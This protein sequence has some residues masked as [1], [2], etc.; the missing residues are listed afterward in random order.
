MK[1]FRFHRNNTLEQLRAIILKGVFWTIGLGLPP[2]TLTAQQCEIF[3]GGNTPH[4][5]KVTVGLYGNDNWLTHHWDFGDGTPIVVGGPEL[6]E[7]SHDYHGNFNPY[8][9]PVPVARHSQDGINWCEVIV[10]QILPYI[11]IGNGCGSQNTLSNL[12]F[13]NKLPATELIGKQ[14]FI[15]GNLEVDIPYKFS[16][17]TILVLGGG[18][19]TVKSGGALTLDQNTMVDAIFDPNDANCQ[20]LWNGIEVMSGGALTTDH[21]SI[22][23][24]YFAISPV[25]PGNINPLPKLSLRNTTFSS[26]FV[27]IYAAAGSFAVSLFINNTFDGSGNNSIYPASTC[28]T[29]PQISGVPYSQRTYCGIYFDGSMGG[30][31]L[32]AGQSTNNLIKEMQ[33]GIVCING[34]SRITGCRFENIAYLTTVTAAHQGTTLTF[35]DNIGGKRLNFVGLGKENLL[36]TITNCERGVYVKTTKPLTEAY[37][38]SCRM[39]EVQNGVEMEETGMG[40]FARGSVY[41]CYIG[42]TK[43]LPNI[44]N[45]STGIEIKDP[46]IAYSNFNINS[47][48][49]EQD[50]PEAYQFT[51]PTFFVFDEEIFPKGIALSTVHSPLSNMDV[52][53]GGNDVTLIKGHHGIS[54]ENIIN[55]VITDNR[56]VNNL[57]GIPFGDYAQIGFFMQGGNNNLLSC[58]TVTQ[59][60]NLSL[61]IIAGFVVSGSYST[62]LSQNTTLDLVSGASFLDDNGTNCSISYNDFQKAAPSGLTKFG[63]YYLNTVTGPQYLKG[64]DWIGDFEAGSVFVS[65]T[66]SF[67][68]CDSRYHVSPEANVDNPINPVDQGDMQ[69]CPQPPNN[70][71]TTLVAQEADYACGGS[72]GG[73]GTLYK[74]EAD[75]NLAD[76]GTLGL[77]SGYKWS[78]E[79]GLYRK[80]TENPGLIGGDAAINGFLQTQQGLP[81][82][83][84]YAVQNSVRDIEVNIPATLTANIKNSLAQLDATEAAML[85]LLED[86]E[87]YPN[88]LASYSALNTQIKNLETLLDGYLTN[89]LSSMAQSAASVMTTNNNINCSDLPCSSERHIYGLYLETQV[90]APRAL[91]I[92]ELE[93]VEEIALYCPKD[94][95]NIVYMARAWYYFLTGEMLYADC[96][97]F[98]PTEGGE[99]NAP[100]Q[101]IAD[102]DMVLMPNPADGSVQVLLTSNRGEGTLTV[103]DL[104]GRLL[105][106]QKVSETVENPPLLIPV[107]GFSEGI[108]LVAFRGNSRKLAAQKLSVK[109]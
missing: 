65:D 32:L 43:Y 80:F 70:W 75:L 81:T 76:G 3:P 90:I 55:A 94:A 106:Q 46:N 93:S 77:S 102:E 104:W 89:A 109:H 15:Y 25:N 11:L 108:Y 41:G 62:T 13:T 48:D 52:N 88:A 103:H 58:N 99:R 20:S 37:V 51:Q 56:V 38:S 4:C 96:G 40:N 21:A 22:R 34:T 57:D 83:A 39:L 82:A 107:E 101:P 74:N 26:N 72:G 98:V 17:C 95:G 36:A 61:A 84:M 30:S 97:S 8:A 42:C 2:Q 66:I 35:I 5:D 69:N 86:I 27:G 9:T 92:P 10:H 53:I 71:F 68:Y 78:S 24:A 23:N 73:S 54:C 18:K 50:Q 6:F 44:K 79:M 59:V 33:A 29:L 85:A 49:I 105:F 14:L 63:L 12:I 45:R 60:S 31:L 91:T 100:S 67:S 1:L 28:D 19:I 87:T 47:N 7:V 64:N 16:G